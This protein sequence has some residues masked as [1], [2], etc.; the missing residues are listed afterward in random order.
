MSSLC[1]VT[2]QSYHCCAIFPASAAHLEDPI[3]TGELHR[4]VPVR[5]GRA[6]TLGHLT[7]KKHRDDPEKM[8]RVHNRRVRKVHIIKE[9]K[10]PLETMGPNV[11][12]LIMPGQKR[13]RVLPG[14]VSKATNGAALSR[15][16]ARP[17]HTDHSSHQGAHQDTIRGERE[18]TPHGS[19]N[20]DSARGGRTVSCSP[21][22]PL[23]N[24][25]NLAC[26]HGAMEGK[27][28]R[29]LPPDPLAPRN[30]SPHAPSPAARHVTDIEL[31]A[32]AGLTRRPQ[33]RSTLVFDSFRVL[34]RQK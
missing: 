34:P 12:R 4:A 5:Q 25:T 11:H 17:Q 13:E 14:R 10:Q 3:S 2:S 19:H 22:A 1:S 23:V 32:P 7:Q 15:Q 30:T 31:R 27:D 26:W 18:P 16:S 9:C 21:R 29:C 8:A 6:Q 24:P 28:T 33:A 20:E